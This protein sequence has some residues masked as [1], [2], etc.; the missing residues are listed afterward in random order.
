MHRPA[1]VVAPREGPPRA[2][3]PRSTCKRRLQNT[4][5]ARCPDSAPRSKWLPEGAPDAVEVV[6]REACPRLLL[7]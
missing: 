6:E 5:K 1:Q 7:F 4:L 3:R 2:A